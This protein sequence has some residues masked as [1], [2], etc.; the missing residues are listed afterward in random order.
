MNA[1]VEKSWRIPAVCD[2]QSIRHFLLQ[3]GQFSRQL[4]KKIRKEG[5]AL[6]NGKPTEL[7]RNMEEGDELVILFP[8]EDRGASM[9]VE[10]G[11][12][13][14]V[15]EDEDLIVLNKPSG[16]AVIPSIDKSEPSIANRL[17][18]YYDEKGLGVTVHI[19]TRLDKYTSGLMVIAKHAYSHMLLTKK[20]KLISRYYEA[21]VEGQ[22][23]KTSGEI[24]RPIGR[25]E[26][27]IIRRTVTG[28]GKP[29]ITRYTVTEEMGSFSRVRFE[30]LTGRTHQIRVHMSSI[31]HPLAGDTL[32]GASEVE[33]FKGQ[34][35]HCRHLTFRHPW[36]KEWIELESPPPVKWRE[37]LN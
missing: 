23:D 34:A 12:L 3:R 14:I 31:G 9:R 15:F 33:G 22:L 5:V 32:Y 21:L 1:S 30:L 10:P 16:I 27:S 29:S 13:E 8:E 25:L 19:V 26:G 24:D 18:A 7:W 35:L 4:L 37:I 28:E 20:E 17:L 6:L 11:P 2:G 36:T